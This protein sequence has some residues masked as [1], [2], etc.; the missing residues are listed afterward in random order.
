MNNKYTQ[1]FE[2]YTYIEIIVGT[3]WS[4]LQMLETV[5]IMDIRTCQLQSLI[6]CIF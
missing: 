4:K 3:S 6:E 5:E 1:I 2:N